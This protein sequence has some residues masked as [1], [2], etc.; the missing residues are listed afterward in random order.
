[1]HGD[2][3]I[4]LFLRLLNFVRFQ[5]LVAASM[6]MTDF[7]DIATFVLFELN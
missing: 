5:V 2:I 6:K 4:N 1:M 3:K 7:W